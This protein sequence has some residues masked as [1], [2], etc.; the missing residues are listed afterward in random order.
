M[1]ELTDKKLHALSTK[2]TKTSELRKLGINGL[3]LKAEEVEAPITNNPVDINTAAYEMLSGWY[4]GQPD[5]KTAF[6]NLCGAL[7][8]AKMGL[9]IETLMHIN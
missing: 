4:K 2:I 6:K 7:R 9:L 3:N 8:E 1:Q 5:T